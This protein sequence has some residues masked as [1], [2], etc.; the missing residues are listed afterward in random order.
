MLLG[1]AA[2]GQQKSGLLLTTVSSASSEQRFHSYWITRDG[3]SVQVVEGMRMLVPR[4]TAWWEVGIAVQKHV[5]SESANETVWAAPVGS[6][7]PRSHSAALTDDDHCADDL[8]TYFVSWVG[9]EFASIHY[10]FEST[11]G[12]HPTSGSNSFMVRL[13]DLQHFDHES[14]A[15]LSLADLAGPAAGEAMKLG[16]EVAESRA[17]QAAENEEE[18]SPLTSQEDSWIVVRAKGHYQ[19]L[20][21]TPESRGHGGETYDIPYD[22]PASLV[23]ANELAVAWDAILDKVPEAL[24]AYTS[25]DGDL[26]VVIAPRFLS[27]FEVKEQKIGARLSRVPMESSAVIAAE[28]SVGARVDRWNPTLVQLLKEAP[29]TPQK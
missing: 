21:T 18:P 5:N 4:K 24:D 13:D 9:T 10:G 7:H 17:P 27:V 16:A 14:R 3:A 23:G 12:P 26:L 22:P 28:W 6:E 20:G 11:C 8:N 1:L 15:H 29:Y 25:P 19:L 2:V